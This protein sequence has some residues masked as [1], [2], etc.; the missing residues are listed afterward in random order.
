MVESSAAAMA[1]GLMVAGRKNIMVVDIGGGTTDVSIMHV[2]GDGCYRI[3]ANAGHRQLG[4][5]VIDETLFHH[6]KRRII[7]ELNV[8]ES[9]VVAINLLLQCR[10]CKEQLSYEASAVIAVPREWVT[11]GSVSSAEEPSSASAMH[12]SVTV[13]QFNDIIRQHTLR[14]QATIS[15]CIA[16]WKKQLPTSGGENAQIDEVVLV[17]GSSRVPVFREAIRAACRD[18]KVAFVSG[19]QELCTGID[20]HQAVAEGLAI[21]GAVLQGINT[22]RL[23]DL[24]LLDCVPNTIG[25]LAWDESTDVVAAADSIDKI[26][27]QRSDRY[28]EPIILRGSRIFAKGSV[29]LS[30]ACASQLQVSLDIYEEIEEYELSSAEDVSVRPVR[31]SYSYHHIVSTDANIPQQGGDNSMNTKVQ[32]EFQYLPDGVLKFEVRR[33]TGGRIADSDELELQRRRK[34]QEGSSNRMMLM[35]VCYAVAM[36]AL[37]FIAKAAFAEEFAKTEYGSHQSDDDNSSVVNAVE[38]VEVS[39]EL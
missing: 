18:E 10:A 36:L 1:Y 3:E 9:K 4:G 24:L 11:D 12:L 23:R 20:A 39:G 21:R 22:N 17:G 19:E 38:K 16:Q 5:D 27:G 13:E 34:D 29:S 32:V 14:L 6:V 15:G 30:L 2:T 31:I 8:V 26:K 25:I 35:L 7:E 28:F 33:C 37:Y